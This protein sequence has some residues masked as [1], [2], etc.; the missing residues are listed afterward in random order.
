[1]RDLLLSKENVLPGRNIMDLLPEHLPAGGAHD[2][3]QHAWWSCIRE[4]SG[5]A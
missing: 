4:A 3:G 2:D 1:M 5:G